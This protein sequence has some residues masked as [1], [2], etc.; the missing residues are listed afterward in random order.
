MPSTLRA[1]ST[2]CVHAVPPSLNFRRMCVLSL[3]GWCCWCCWLQHGKGCSD[4]CARDSATYH[5]ALASL[6][7]CCACAR[8]C[9]HVHLVAG[10]VY[11]TS[12]VLFCQHQQLQCITPAKGASV[13]GARY[14][15]LH[16][17]FLPP[18]C[19]PQSCLSGR[20]CMAC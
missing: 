1:T 13:I 18:P 17:F 7:S 20:S 12:A 3:L 14:F 8:A 19:W 4:R 2:W 5:V 9:V 10:A 11:L 16:F 6:S 15:F